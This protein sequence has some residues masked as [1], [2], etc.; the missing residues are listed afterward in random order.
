MPS[1]A[2]VVVLARRIRR[3]D[4]ARR[5]STDRTPV[6][7]VGD[8]ANVTAIAIGAIEAA[9]RVARDRAVVVGVKP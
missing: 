4:R 6:D 9:N 8:D 1:I 2:R 3:L 5:A 7:D